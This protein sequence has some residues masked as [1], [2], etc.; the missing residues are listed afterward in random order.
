MLITS[1]APVMLAGVFAIPHDAEARWGPAAAWRMPVGDPARLGAPSGPES[2]PFKILR[3]VEWSHG[4]ASHQGADLGN[5]RT[6]DTVTAAASG[7][8]VLSLDGDNGNGYGG[9]VVVA[10]HLPEGSLVYTVYAHLLDGTVMVRPGDEVLAGDPLGR[11]GQTGRA[12]APHLHFEVRTPRDPNDRWENAG[13]IEPLA[14]VESRM[15]DPGQDGREEPY[16][17]WAAAEG[18]VDPGVRADET[19]TRERWWRMLAGSLADG[20][21]TRVPPAALCDSLIDAGLLPEEESGAPP[22]EPVSWSEAARDV[23]RLRQYGVRLAHGPLAA[24]DHVARCEQRFG[25]R[26]PS[27]RASALG[28]RSDAPCLRDACMLVADVS[29]PRPA[30]A[31]R[32]TSASAASARPRAAHH[33]R[34]GK[35]AH[36]HGARSRKPTGHAKARAKPAAKGPARAKGA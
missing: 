23:K 17:A 35:S 26:S 29:G 8:V 3:T 20:P 32:A 34:P 5:G 9:H 13:V 4:R 31:V 15:L 27:S 14:F 16:V 25:V 28:H 30:G 6:G 2:P 24:N 21:P 36:A 33:A 18:L 19:L 7:L 10:H 12:S 1:L 11:V 22:A